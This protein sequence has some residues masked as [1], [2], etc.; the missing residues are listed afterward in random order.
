MEE[1]NSR[2]H[3]IERHREEVWEL[4]R[5]SDEQLHVLGQHVH[6]LRLLF[7]FYLP[8]AQLTG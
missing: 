7:V 5:T 4:P 2:E 3:R 8:L 6:N 1:E